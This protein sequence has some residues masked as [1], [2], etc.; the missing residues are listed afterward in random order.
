MAEILQL[1]TIERRLYPPDAIP[2]AFLLTESNLQRLRERYKLKTLGQ[3]VGPAGAIAGLTGT[4]GEFSAASGL[5]VIEQLILQPT[6]IHVQISGGSDIA[7]E[8][9]THLV[10]VLCEIGNNNNI[11]QV[12][13]TTRTYQT[14]AIA[15]LRL[16]SECLFSEK[17]REFLTEVVRPKVVLPGGQ[18]DIVLERLSWAVRYKMD[19]TDF[20]Y[21]PKALTIE[22]RQG[23]KPGDMIYYTVSPTQSRIHL[24]LLETLESKFRE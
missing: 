4:G 13:E 8:F 3:E 18:P 6:V 11:L 7:D 5:Q 2:W 23:S 15:K 17:I 19:T 24:E 9:V 12:Q 21:I 22:P 16:P 14:V 20:M 1:F 10:Q